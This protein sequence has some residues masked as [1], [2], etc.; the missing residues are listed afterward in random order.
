MSSD[1]F[2]C[3]VSPCRLLGN[4]TRGNAAAN[5]LNELN[6]LNDLNE[7][8]ELNEL[9]PISAAKHESVLSLY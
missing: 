1:A 4:R 8:N 2:M 9:W 6:D 3:S 5:Q 7:L